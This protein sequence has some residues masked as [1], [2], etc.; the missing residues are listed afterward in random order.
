MSL[1]AIGQ[2]GVKDTIS[3][4]FCSIQF[5]SYDELCIAPPNCDKGPLKTRWKTPGKKQHHLEEWFM[6]NI[7]SILHNFHKFHACSHRPTPTPDNPHCPSCAI[8]RMWTA[9]LASSRVMSIH[10]ATPHSSATHPPTMC[11]PTVMDSCSR[12]QQPMTRHKQP[13]HLVSRLYSLVDGLSTALPFLLSRRGLCQCVT[14]GW[15]AKPDKKII[16][17]KQACESHG[18]ILWRVDGACY[19]THEK[20]PYHPPVT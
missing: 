9:G 8:T 16:A 17:L 14:D 1:R 19:I 3:S 7:L 2:F 10:P 12:N 11:P 13:H 5:N 18:L 20:S 15:R 6:Y 4:S